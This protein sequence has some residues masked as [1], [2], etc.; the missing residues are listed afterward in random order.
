[1]YV[2]LVV[3]VA[4]CVTKMLCPSAVSDLFI[5]VAGDDNSPKEESF[6]ELVAA[7]SPLLHGVDKAFTDS[8]TEKIASTTRNDK[9]TSTRME[10]YP[11]LT[12]NCV[13]MNRQHSLSPPSP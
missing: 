5:M 13:G 1:M 10:L 8:W 6:D 9:R 3:V 7:C 12:Q 2:L 11:F 4:F